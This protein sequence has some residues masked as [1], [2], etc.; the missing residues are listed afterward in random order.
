LLV[1]AL[2]HDAASMTEAEKLRWPF[3]ILALVV[4]IAAVCMEVGS[5]FFLTTPQATGTTQH[6]LGI[7]SLWLVDISLLWSTLLLSAQ[8]VVNK[9]VVGRL[10]GLVTLVLSIVVVILGIIKLI[11]AFVLLMVM[12]SLIVSFFGIIVYIALFGHFDTSAANTVL[13]AITFFKVAFAI[14]LVL[15]QQ[16]FLQSKGLVFLIVL[17][18]LC[19][20][21]LSILYAIV[22]GLLVSITDAVG[23]IVICIIAIIYAIV[24]AIFGIVAVIRAVV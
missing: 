15:A 22:P 3:L 4:L 12:L 24:Q 9:N 11:E 13:G 6:Q 7:P 2:D 8:L 23:A 19:N 21:L 18:L 5:T 1:S 10:Q 17:S 20:L 14:L 16:R